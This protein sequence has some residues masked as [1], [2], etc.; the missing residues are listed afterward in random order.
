MSASR[1]WL[2]LALLLGA[3]CASPEPRK[4]ASRPPPAP[5]P[6]KVDEG[7]RVAEVGQYLIYPVQWLRAEEVAETL[8]PILQSRYGSAVR[9][10]PH[11][12]TNQ[13]IIYIPTRKE[14]EA[15][16]RGGVAAQQGT[17]GA[18][19]PRGPAPATTRAPTPTGT[20]TG[21]SRGMRTPGGTR[22]RTSTS[23]F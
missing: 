16:L 13:L 12:A 17:P 20:P 5:R 15:S 14:T 10:I 4:E 6:P 18:G 23:G 1:R 3:G 11:V 2:L 8:Y 22:S 9:I 21:T 19:V 7:I